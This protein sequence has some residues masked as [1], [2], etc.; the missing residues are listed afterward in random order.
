VNDGS[1]YRVYAIP[2]ES[3][4][5]GDRTLA[6][7]RADAEASPFGWHDTDGAPGAE[8]TRTQGNNV[9]AYTDRIAPANVPDP[10]SDPDGG[11]GLDFD[12]SVDLTLDP[13]DYADGA[14][15]NLF[16]SNNIIHDV[17]WR[18][19]FNEQAGNYQVN[20]YG[21]GGNGNDWVRA[22]AQD[23][24]DTN[25]ANFSPGGADGGLPRMQMFLWT[26]ARPNVVEIAP[27]SP[28][29]GTYEASGA[30][31][32]P[33]LAVGAPISG[34]VVIGEDG[35]GPSPTD[36]CEPL[37]GFPA[38]SI[39]LV[40]RGNC[41]FTVKV[42][43]AQDAGSPAVIVANNVAGNPI[44]M[45]GEDA[46][47][48]IPSVMVTLDTGNAIKAG[49]PATA[50]LS[51]DPAR[52]L[53]RDGD[54][55]AGIIAHEYGHGVSNRL[56]GGPLTPGCLSGN[57]QMGEG[58]SDWQAVS[59]TALPT[60][61]EAGMR[62][63]GDYALYQPTRYDQGIR[64]TAYSTDTGINPATY[65]TIKTA[66]V[67][68]GVGYVWSTMPWEVYWN[69]VDEYGFNP[70]VYGPWF[71]GGN[72]LAIQLVHDGMKFQVCDPG[73]V[74]GRD[75]ILAADV[76]LT[77]GE[78]QCLIWRGF[79]KRGLG[80]NAA[81]G[82]S[83]SRSDGTQAF[84]PHPECFFV[85]GQVE[86]APAV[87]RANAGSSVP[88]IFSL[89]GDRGL[90]IFAAGSPSSRQI[91]CTTKAPLGPSSPTQTPG[92]SRLTYDASTDAYTYVW[93]TNGSWQGTCRQLTMAFADGS[94]YTAF[95]SFT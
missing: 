59:L 76:G 42:K 29:A 20:N 13:V 2:F 25:N 50:T 12:F 30:A 5:D 68:H 24:A 63:V 78:N 91:D 31:F 43:N 62:G 73:F 93:R 51:R 53:R 81:Q 86:H 89:V 67:P 61:T 3:P 16:Y 40:D 87:T 19:G 39:A 72:N 52:G 90:D 70:N 34:S 60:D 7:N 55:D 38:G 23:S 17:L 45:G 85:G 44:T 8:F 75:A 15:T 77:G 82:T 48:T 83:G 37:V 79:V 58:W 54:L 66:A 11:A 33:P 1:S 14:V 35:A 92:S 71:S 9:H 94:E 21:R 46:T 49:L 64:P 65:D 4:N 74:D 41:N 80:F 22:E 6:Q 18:Y 95:L 47:I 88:L 69:L 56:T 10:G 27:P 32:G 26:H 28:A 84:N 36:G 57:E